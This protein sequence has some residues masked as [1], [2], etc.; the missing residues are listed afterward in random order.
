MQFANMIV[1]ELNVHRFENVYSGDCTPNTI[2]MPYAKGIRVHL[3]TD[4]QMR[5]F[6]EPLSI[7]ISPDSLSQGEQAIRQAIP[8]LYF[9]MSQSA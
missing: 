1:S 9:D 5:Q 3:R 6:L 7:E 2:I 8:I 4:C